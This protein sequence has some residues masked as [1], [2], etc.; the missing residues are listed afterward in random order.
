MKEEER[1][2]QGRGDWGKSINKK[3]GNIVA[4]LKKKIQS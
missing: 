3:E 1:Y 4:S 2:G